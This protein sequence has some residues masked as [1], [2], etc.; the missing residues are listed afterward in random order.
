MTNHITAV[1]YDPLEHTEEGERV[2]LESPDTDSQLPNDGVPQ[3]SSLTAAAPG[4]G[5]GD[6]SDAAARVYGQGPSLSPRKK[7]LYGVSF[8]AVFAGLFGGLAALTQSKSRGVGDDD[9]RVQG[10]PASISVFVSRLSYFNESVL[11]GYDQCGDL[12]LDL[13][14]AIELLGNI[15]IDNWATHHFSPNY[16]WYDYV[17]RGGGT[18]CIQPIMDDIILMEPEVAMREDVDSSA[19]PDDKV[20][21]SPPNGGEDSFGTNNQVQGVDEAD[22]VKSD[23]THV[24]AAYTDK[25]MVWNADNGQLL[26]KT[27]IPTE[28]D[29]GIP[30]CSIMDA[31]IK[32]CLT[33]MDT[34]LKNQ[35]LNQYGDALDT[36]YTG[37][38]PLFDETTGEEKDRLHYLLEKFPEFECSS[39]VPSPIEGAK[40]YEYNPPYFMWW[41]WSNPEPIAISSLMLH[42]GKLIV[43]ASSE[44][45]LRGD[46]DS[47]ILRNQKSTRVFVFDVSPQAIPIDGVS[48][49]TLLSRKDF[50]GTYKTARSIGQYVHIV[51]STDLN[52]ETILSNRLSPR[53]EE[54]F[55]MNET[56][57]R[58]GAYNILLDTAES[59]ASN[60]TSELIEIIDPSGMDDCTKLAKVALMLKAAD[61]DSN[62]TVLPSFTLNSAL[63]TLTLVH[64]FD[65]SQGVA[66]TGVSV[67]TVTATSSGVFLPMQS[68]TS[69][70]YMSSSKLVIAGESYVQNSNDGN[71]D[72]HT[73]F[74]VFNLA[75]DTSTPESVG[76]VPGSLLNQFS[77]DHY[78][79][80]NTQEDYLRVATTTW[81]RWGLINDTVWGQTQSSESQV[82]VLKIGGSSST[83]E[84]VGQVN[85]IGMGERIYAV[86]FVGE[87]AFVVTFMQID[88]FYTL[89]MSDPTNPRVVG[90]LKIPGFS[91]YLHPVNEDLVLALG[92]NTTE[93]GRTDGLQ[94]SLFDVSNFASPQRVRQYV[95]TSSNSMSDAQ[96][97]HKA[98]RYLP[99]SKLLILPLSVNPWCGSTDFAT[100]FF[101]GFVV[102]DVD[103]SRD[104]SK[105][106]N[107]S[108]VNPKDAC[109]YCWSRDE[110]S[111]R[112]LVFS[113]AVMTLKG[114]NVLSHELMDGTFRW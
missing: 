105:K 99:E 112:S 110:L 88:P 68:Y 93:D 92:Q 106:F 49:L 64:S 103:E 11:D 59:L 52:L 3:G 58:S 27:V 101:D 24:F 40:C 109:D 97:E 2:E 25:V 42:E 30:L 36:M 10:P 67:E 104:F 8:V 62:S 65:V 95:E 98:F 28:D 86:R 22:L 39:T 43:V 21:S 82:T 12:E 18:G 71:W 73:V 41:G 33:E 37:G 48:P 34:W 7:A 1:H 80:E 60:L 102:Y 107:I 16:Y 87:R 90:E 53:N 54:F 66:T 108:H 77:M 100:S 17:C 20:S 83:L 46:Q 84:K 76:D 81:G 45:S 38:S 47:T 63:R 94:I 113:G 14:E 50:Q 5:N 13:A 61:E 32:D 78:F 29:E 85:G 57:Y 51:T 74:L 111:P 23:G 70:V 89:D 4:S 31:S 15:T 72:E 114:H 96:Y 26:S 75:N 44:Y 19:P 56:E 35:A 91:N 9:V 55:K 6:P 69:N 79:D